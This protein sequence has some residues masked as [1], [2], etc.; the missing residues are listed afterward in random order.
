MNAHVFIGIDPG[1]VP[2][3]VLIDWFT[4]G[5]MPR[6]EVVQCSRGVAPLILRAFVLDHQLEEPPLVQIERFVVGKRAGRSSSAKA[7][8]Q[9]RDLIGQLIASVPSLPAES[10]R[11]RAAGE[12]KPWATDE[13]LE[14]A[15]LLDATKGMRH[16]RDAARHALFVAVKDGGVSDPL[17]RK[18][19]TA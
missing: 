14:A 6:L 1:P 15:G 9:T 4:D 10:W 5:P 17:S 16:A 2:G 11:A 3:F 7:G 12:V 8:E 13:R 19:H 18:A